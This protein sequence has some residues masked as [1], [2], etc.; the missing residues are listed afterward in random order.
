MFAEGMT[1]PIAPWIALFLQG[2]AFALVV[3]II[4]VMYPKAAKEAREERERRDVMFKEILD[5]QNDNFEKRNDKIVEALNEQSAILQ[6]Q[7]EVLRDVKKSSIA[8]KHSSA[9]QVKVMKGEDAA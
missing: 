6:E 7:T 5:S 9:E 4:A 2:G 3:Y 8:I 1:D